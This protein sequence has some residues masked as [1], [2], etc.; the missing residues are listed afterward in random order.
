MKALQPRQYQICTLDKNHDCTACPIKSQVDCSRHRPERMTWFYRQV[1]LFTVPGLLLLAVASFMS[2]IWWLIPVYVLFWALYQIV[3]ELFIHC[4]HCPFWD[5][6]SPTLECRINCGV[7]KVGS[8]LFKTLMKYDPKPLALWEKAAILAFN[9][10]AAAL[11]LGASI[12]TLAVYIPVKGIADP[13]IITILLLTAIF[14]AAVIVFLIR[15]TRHL[16]R[17]CVHFSCPMNRQPYRVIER[18]LAMNPYIRNA[19]APELGKY[20]HRK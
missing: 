16:C 7:P 3:G 20:T 1:A 18:Y 2:H 4:R 11:P 15:L 19:W 9:A 5:E 12:A 17:T 13:W 14:I 10:G 8:S 6:S